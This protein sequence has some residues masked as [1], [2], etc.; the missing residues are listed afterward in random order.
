MILVAALVPA[1]LAGELTGP[2][3]GAFKD[4]GTGPAEGGAL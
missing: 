1:A 3:M 4:G 2:G